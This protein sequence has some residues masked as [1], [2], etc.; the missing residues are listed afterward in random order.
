M[1]EGS[2]MAEPVQQKH[3]LDRDTEIL[4]NNFSETF[5]QIVK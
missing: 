4:K 5:I 3:H 2:D 1:C